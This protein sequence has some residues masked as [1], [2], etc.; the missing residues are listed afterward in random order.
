VHLIL[1]L[2]LRF[3]IILRN[4]VN[5]GTL[6]FSA[7]FDVELTPKWRASVNA[8]SIWFDDTAVLELFLNQPGIDRHFGDEIN[9]TTQYRPFLNNNVIITAGGSVFFP[10][11]GFE[12]IFGSDTELYQLFAGF[13]LVY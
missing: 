12:D 10:G 13:T 5:P 7:G 2:R 3:A 11:D 6:V 8:N 4:F 9:L 1:L